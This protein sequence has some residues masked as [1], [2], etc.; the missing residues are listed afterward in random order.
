MR[1]MD[2]SHEQFQTNILNQTGE[3]SCENTKPLYALRIGMSWSATS[4]RNHNEYD[5]L[6][7][8]LL[9]IVAKKPGML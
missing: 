6:I 7:E 5:T 1:P 3:W 2:M 8:D 9:R 4:K